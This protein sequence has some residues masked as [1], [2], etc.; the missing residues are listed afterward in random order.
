ME[1]YNIFLGAN[2]DAI[3][4][5]QGAIETSYAAGLARAYTGGGH[6]DWFLPSKDELNEIYQNKATINTAAASNGGSDLTSSYYWSSKELDSVY[7]GFQYF[8]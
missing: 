7:A 6:N 5:V 4:T 1:N 2:T 3:I 8:S